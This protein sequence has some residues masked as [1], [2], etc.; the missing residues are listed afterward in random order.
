MSS[1]FFFLFFF[2]LFRAAPRA[3]GSVPRLGVES[4]LQLPVYT[5]ATATQNR[6]HV[7][8]L[9]HSSQQ[10]QIPNP[11][12]ENR[13]QTHILMDTSW[14]R[15]HCATLGTP[16]SSSLSVGTWTLCTG[17]RSTGNLKGISFQKLNFSMLFSLKWTY[18]WSRVSGCLSFFTSAWQLPSATKNK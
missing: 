10:R 5:T 4:E 7:C 2:F 9:H 13:D 15:F 1:S 11:L 8:D 18:L 14:I 16:I 6:S 12:S 3:Y 17:Y